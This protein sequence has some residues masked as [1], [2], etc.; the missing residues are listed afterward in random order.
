ML[1]EGTGATVVCVCVTWGH[2]S[3][4]GVI[5]EGTGATVVLPEGTDTAVVCVLP[6][7]TGAAV[8]AVLSGKA[9]QQMDTQQAAGRLHS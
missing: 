5:P 6:E 3:S 7:G 1:P 4:V 8:V 2:C 9:L